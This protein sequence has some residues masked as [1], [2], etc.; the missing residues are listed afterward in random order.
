MS[1][2]YIVAAV[3]LV[4]TVTA[5]D[6][7]LI[8]CKVCE[9]AIEHVWNQGEELRTKC[10]ESGGNSGDARCNFIHLHDHGIEDMMH[11]VC[12]DLP[13]TY[14]AIEGSEFDMVLHEDPQHPKEIA[15][16]IKRAC[17]NYLHDDHGADEVAMYIF[18]NLDAGKQK[19]Q[20]LPALQH[21]YCRQA[22]TAEYTRKRDHHDSSNDEL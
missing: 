8:R 22:C 9:R 20:I 2:T 6:D 1:V 18:A 21:R 17:V 5:L 19:E 14:K 13:K 15:L 16:A 12:D 11:T 3:L 10:T 4:A 7:K